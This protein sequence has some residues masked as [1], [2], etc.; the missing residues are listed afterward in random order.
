MALGAVP[1]AAGVILV[2]NQGVLHHRF[3]PEGL[4][5][6]QGELHI[7][8]LE[9]GVLTIRDGAQMS[10]KDALEVADGRV[11]GLA[12]SFFARCPVAEVVEVR[13]GIAQPHQELRGG[14]CVQ[15]LA[16]FHRNEVVVAVLALKAMEKVRRHDDVGVGDQDSPPG[17]VVNRLIDH[18]SLVRHVCGVEG[19]AHGA[20]LR[21]NVG[22][23]I[24]DVF[25]P[26]EGGRKKDRVQLR[27]F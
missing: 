17:R 7:G 20:E 16:S 18:E 12:N 22:E 23:A 11:L 6:V 2:K 9:V 21:A 26:I 24:E 8:S 1:A 15:H 25:G 5:D 19:N 27:E 10:A 13:H 4:P 3:V 14:L